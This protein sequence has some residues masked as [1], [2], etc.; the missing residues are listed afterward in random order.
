MRIV[1]RHYKKSDVLSFFFFL[2]PHENGFTDLADT[3]EDTGEERQTE[4]EA[5]A[6]P[7]D[8]V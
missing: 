5:K 1:S 3:L 8:Q 6:A 4:V 7:E 2:L